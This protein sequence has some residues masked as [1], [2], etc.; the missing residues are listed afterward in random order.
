MKKI[1]YTV[2]S[3]NHLAY[4]KTMADSFVQYNQGYSV[5]ICLIDKIKGRFE[6]EFFSPHTIIE[7]KDIG[8]HDFTGMSEKYTIIELNC[9]V[10]PFMASYLFQKHNPEIL[11]YFDSDVCFYH[12]IA[13]IEA[14]LSEHS[15]LLTPHILTPYSDDANPKER[16]LL[17]SGIYN[18]GFLA[19]RN[20]VTANNF[21]NWW[22]N[23]LRTQCY[24]NFAEGMGVDQNWLNLVTLFFKGTGIV[25]HMGA[26]VAY[27]NLHE[28]N[29]T[30]KEGKWVINATWPLI[31]FHISG[32]KFNAPE[33][34]SLHQDRIKLADFPAVKELLKEYREK[35]EACGHTKFSKLQCYYAKPPKKASTIA[36]VINYALAF[37]GLKVVKA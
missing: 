20:S 3:A 27:W 8:I 5:F 16:D 33:V 10:K 26:N 17:R 23:R 29:L 25:Q 37:L 18:A 13:P 19:L 9:A 7:V 36:R 1:V 24:Y 12:S 34:L 14:L 2:C 15:L 4:A 22:A 11:F 31:F 35:V 32:Y 30:R 21:L 28:R 6:A